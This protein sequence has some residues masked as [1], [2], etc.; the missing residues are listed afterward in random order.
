MVRM[1]KLII[2]SI[3]FLLLCLRLLNHFLSACLYMNSSLCAVKHVTFIKKYCSVFCF[4]LSQPVHKDLKVL[5]RTSLLAFTFKYN[6]YLN[7]KESTYCIQMRQKLM[8]YC[9]LCF[10]C[11]L[12]KI[13]QGIINYLILLFPVQKIG[14]CSYKI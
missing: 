10:D 13:S 4:V 8:Q 6:Y 5:L 14:G 2:Q 1:I 11:L 9:Q 12:L 7:H 3:V